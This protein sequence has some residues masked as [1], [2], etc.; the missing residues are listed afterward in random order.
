M[1]RT[2]VQLA[3]ILALLTFVL[4]LNSNKNPFDTFVFAGLVFIGVI[5][6]VLLGFYFIRT[7]ISFMENQTNNQPEINLES[8]DNAIESEEI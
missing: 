7:G 5:F 2:F 6:I 1:N 4:K 8:E 3:A